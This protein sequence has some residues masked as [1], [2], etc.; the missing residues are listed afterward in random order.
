MPLGPL[1]EK[2][3]MIELK[4]SQMRSHRRAVSL[5]TTRYRTENEELKMGENGF[6]SIQTMLILFILSLSVLGLGTGISMTQKYYYKN[7]T[8]QQDL[9]LLKAEVASI[10]KQ[11]ESDPTPESDSRIDPVWSYIEGQSSKYKHIRLQDVSSR[12]NPNW[13]RSVFFERT[14]LKKFLLNGVSPDMLKDHRNEV[15]YMIDIESGY[16]E[17]IDPEALDTFFTPYS[18]LNVNTAYEYVLKD[19]YELITGD[20]VGATSFHSF[21]TSAMTS[22][23]IITEEELLNSAGSDYEAIYPIISTLPEMN[24]HFV[25]EFI[26][27]QVLAHPYGGEVID[28][29]SSIYNTLLSLR[30]SDE[31]TL[32]ELQSLIITEGLQERVFHH[33]GTKTW[34]WKVEI[35]NDRMAIEA[36]IVCFPSNS[37][38]ETAYNYQLYS[39]SEIA[40]E[41][42]E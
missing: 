36:I 8:I 29:N 42:T 32:A 12:I 31:I 16:S 13:V 41:Q 3:L 20:S 30:M 22:K 7:E 24:V 6:S 17:L 14:D 35:A 15:G 25:P 10:I 33:L 11:L 2:Y 28:N 34:F 27:E 9:I 19:M 5:R 1:E 38:L 4:V 40:E 37:E 26:L 21:I 39:F 23:H 18:Y